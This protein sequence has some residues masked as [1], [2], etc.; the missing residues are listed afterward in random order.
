M[1]QSFDEIPANLIPWILSQKLFWVATAPIAEDG[2]VN[3]SPKGCFDKTINIIREEREPGGKEPNARA[4]WYE[5]LTGSGVET[6]S[7]IYE[8][9]RITL[10]FS[11]FE[12][13]PQIVRV[14]GTGKVYEYG[15]PQYKELLPHDRREPGS[16]AAIWIDIHR[17]S[18]SCGY[19]IPFF[20]YKA[21]RIKL[22]KM[23]MVFEQNEYGLSEESSAVIDGYVMDKTSSTMWT[24]LNLKSIDG[25]PAM[26]SAYA[27]GELPTNWNESPKAIVYRAMKDDE[28]RPKT[29]TQVSD[30]DT[31]TNLFAAGRIDR[32]FGI[33]IGI[34]I[35]VFIT[36]QWGL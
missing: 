32:W 14:Y 3:V 15:T 24:L 25:L 29:K 12:G 18:T 13:P 23:S 4:I 10:M 35:G 8:N 26:T 34:V 20:T 16:R 22:H 7:H 6:I 27:C 1:G 21:P 28:T 33:A 5:D 36:R 9:G 19:S 17:V 11:A 30:A 2:H 31:T